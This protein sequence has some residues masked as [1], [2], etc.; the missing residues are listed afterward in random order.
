MRAEA[1]LLQIDPKKIRPNDENPRIHFPDISTQKLINS[2]SGVG[3]LVPVSVYEDS[4]KGLPLY[5]LLDGERRWRCAK[6]LGLPTMPA[7]V[8]PPPDSTENLLHMFHIHM[9]RE[10]WEPMPTAWALKKLTERTGKDSPTELSKMTGLTTNYI[11]Q[12]QYA[13]GLP[14]RFQRMIDEKQIP[15]N[16]FYELETQFLRPLKSYRPRIFKMFGRQE[17]LAAFVDKKIEKVTKDTLELR[18]LRSIIDVAAREARDEESV[19]EFDSAIVNLIRDKSRTIQE[20]YE[21]T[22]EMVI[23]AGRFSRQCK[24]LIAKFDRLLAKSEN[25]GETEVIV[26]SLRALREQINDRLGK[27]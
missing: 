13:A 24:Q 10:E 23:E 4:R 8:L 25:E 21:D 26:N 2:I 9:V 27:I 14:D 20:A 6:K 1:G 3:V 15:L 11:K 16:F 22:V 7:I 18:K 5:V 19:S 17:I 12:L